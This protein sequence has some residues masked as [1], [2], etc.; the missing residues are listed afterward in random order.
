MLKTGLRIE[1]WSE[2]SEIADPTLISRYY[3]QNERKKIKKWMLKTRLRM[4]IRAKLS[5][6]GDPALIHTP[7]SS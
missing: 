1:I 2:S 3:K 4:Q 5:D 7:D 6:M